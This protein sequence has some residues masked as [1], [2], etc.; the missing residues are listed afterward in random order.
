MTSKNKMNKLKNS[1]CVPPTL[2]NKDDKLKRL[3]FFTPS[4]RKKLKQQ[5]RKEVEQ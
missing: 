2:K 1:Y 3:F 5:T 4:M